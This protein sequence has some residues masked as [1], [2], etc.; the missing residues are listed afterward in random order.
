MSTVSEVLPRKQYSGGSGCG[1]D[2]SIKNS[3]G[4]CSLIN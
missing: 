4:F 3:Y 1:F 2:S